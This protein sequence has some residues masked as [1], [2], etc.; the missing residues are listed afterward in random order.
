MEGEFYSSLLERVRAA[1]GAKDNIEYFAKH[2][3]PSYKDDMVGRGQLDN[4]IA[5]ALDIALAQCEEVFCDL[6]GL[7]L[8]GASYLRA[9]A[10][11][12][13]PG[14][15]SVRETHY[16][17]HLG[18]AEILARHASKDLLIPL[19]KDFLS[20][21]HQAE[22]SWT[23][24][25]K[26]SVRMAE[27]ALDKF[28]D[29]IWDTVNKFID[30]A[31]IVRPNAIETDMIADKFRAEIP[32]GDPKCLGNVI[33]ASW[34]RFDEIINSQLPF[35][36]ICE[37]LSRLNEMGLKTVEALEYIRRIRG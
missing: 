30:M 10:Y 12:L 5:N 27:I 3:E 25:T 19:P 6:L 15:G 7:A 13:S 28:D 14:L 26:F 11:I 21:F 24:T 35:E 16:P 8:F 34:I 23:N 37:E 29:Q 33:N 2:V 31:D 17:A 18:R 22:P 4:I 32:S 1:C 9:F 36:V 20:S